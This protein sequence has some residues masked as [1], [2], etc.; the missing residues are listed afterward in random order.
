MTLPLTVALLVA[1]GWALAQQDRAW[2]EVPPPPEMPEEE[3]VPPPPVLDERAREQR[4]LEDPDITIIEREGE[5]RREYRVRGELVMVE[6]IPAVGPPYYLI[7][8]T[9]DGSMDTRSHELAPA[10]IPPA[11]ILFRW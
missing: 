5:T 6:V 4:E 11:W 9:G 3:A 10:F 7:D 1:P 2:N 8:T